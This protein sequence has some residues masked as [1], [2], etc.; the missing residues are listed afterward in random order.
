MALKYY[1]AT[2]TGEG[3][4]THEDNETNFITGHPGNL[5]TTKNTSW[6]TRV[7]AT[8]VTFEEAQAIISSSLSGTFD[9]TYTSSTH[10]SGSETF[11]QTYIMRDENGEE[12]YDTPATYS[13]PEE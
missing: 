6:A 7:G 9:V 3:F 4:I 1:T 8:E 2:N 5:W 11:T 10:I 12:V 13:L